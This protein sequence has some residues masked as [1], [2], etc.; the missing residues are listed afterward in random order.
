M[1]TS[2]FNAFKQVCFE[3][4]PRDHVWYD[5][6]AWF[7]LTDRQCIQIAIVL[8]WVECIK[9]EVTSEGCRFTTPSGVSITSKDPDCYG[10]LDMSGKR[11]EVWGGV[12]IYSSNVIRA[13]NPV[14]GKEG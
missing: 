5:M 13:F 4:G 12:E 3:A 9:K 1:K 11:S 8:Q 7:T 2:L 10:W 6:G 14:Y